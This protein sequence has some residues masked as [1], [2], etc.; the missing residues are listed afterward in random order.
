MK[1]ALL[2][3]ALTACDLP[4]DASRVSTQI[5]R[6][7]GSGALCTGFEH[8]GKTQTP[9]DGE[10]LCTAHGVELMCHFRWDRSSSEWTLQHACAPLGPSTR[11]ELGP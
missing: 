3:I 10:L 9:R 4:P 7:L 1:L 11:P 5:E 6:E 2:A 8:I